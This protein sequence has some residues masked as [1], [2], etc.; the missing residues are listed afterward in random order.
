MLDS[1]SLGLLRQH[2]CPRWRL[3]PRRARRAVALIGSNGA[4][5]STTL[6][7]I[8]GLLRPAP[9]PSPIR[10][11]DITR[12]PTDRI[13]ASGISQCPEGRHIFGAMT[14][15]ENLRLGAASRSDRV[16]YDKNMAYVLE[17]SAPAR[18]PGSI[19]RHPLRWRTTDACHRARPHEP[20]SALTAR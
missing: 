14:V 17:S 5:K 4:G 18:T 2:P 15:R 10:G 16:A 9:A 12:A 19:G 11:T 20:A 3:A 8:S 1:K 13:V 7:S 6:K